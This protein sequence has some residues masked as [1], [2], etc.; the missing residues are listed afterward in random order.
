ME[1]LLSPPTVIYTNDNSVLIKYNYKI[2]NGNLNLMYTSKDVNFSYLTLVIISLIPTFINKLKKIELKGIEKNLE[3]TIIKYVSLL[4]N[5]RFLNKEITYLI[6]RSIDCENKILK[7]MLQLYP[8]VG[9]SYKPPLKY[10]EINKIKAVTKKLPVNIGKM[11]SN[12]LFYSKIFNESLMT[13]E[14]NNYKW[15]AKVV[16]TYEKCHKEEGYPIN[17]FYISKLVDEKKSKIYYHVDID[18]SLIRLIPTLWLLT[19]YLEI[20]IPREELIFGPGFLDKIIENRINAAK[21]FLNEYL[22]EVPVNFFEKISIASTFAS[23]GLLKLAPFLLDQNIEEVYI[24]A[25]QRNIYLDHSEWGRCETNLSLNEEDIERFATFLKVESGLQLD[26]GSPSLKTDINTNLFKLR[27]SID[28]YPLIDEKYSLVIRKFR[29]RPLTII[30]LINNGTITVDAAT[31]LLISLAHRC[32]ILVV[33]EPSSGKT[34]LINALDIMTPSYWR[35]ISIEEVIESLNL[36]KYG[37]HQVRYRV[38]PFEKDISN[39]KRTVETIKLLHRSP[40]YI[41]FGELLTQKNVSIFLQSLEAGLH[42]IQTTHAASP[43]SLIRKWILHYKIP[44][45]SLEHINV[46]VHMKREISYNTNRR[47][48]YR[49]VEPILDFEKEKYHVKLIDLFVYDGSERKLILL[50]DIKESNVF[51]KISKEENIPIEELNREFAE[52]KK[53]L[54]KLMNSESD[55]IDL[56]HLL[57][58]I[59]FENRDIK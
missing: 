16:S 41:F 26:H 7:E 56:S 23:L 17:I 53:L 10:E 58:K 9:F 51:K 37:K 40:N 3:K 13:I 6:S 34:T 25:P 38:D 49:I 29:N 12:L 44:I 54:I 39:K 20:N 42:G 15:D 30:D 47:F 5:L 1:T 21:N 43:E 11:L 8:E 32:N 22:V 46:I 48:V 33:G 55:L 57:D 27:V 45:Q 28:A 35:K 18:K 31:Y 59:I 2:Y 4:S 14:G 19:T 24:D 36:A 52:C 50:K